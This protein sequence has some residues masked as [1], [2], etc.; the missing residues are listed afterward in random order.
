MIAF[1]SHVKTTLELDWTSYPTTHWWKGSGYDQSKFFVDSGRGNVF[2]EFNSNGRQRLAENLADSTLKVIKMYQ[3]CGYRQDYLRSSALIAG[4]DFLKQYIDDIPEDI[5]EESLP[6]VSKHIPAFSVSSENRPQVISKN[7][8]NTKLSKRA[9]DL[10]EAEKNK[11]ERLRANQDAYRA[12]KK[13]EKAL[14]LADG[15]LL[16]LEK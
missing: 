6:E 5:A 14:P 4:S 12:R 3:S 10:S 15:I 9:P 16:L 7:I 1:Q 2:A 13:A 11:K 8:S